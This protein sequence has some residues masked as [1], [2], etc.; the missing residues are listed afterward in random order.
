MYICTEDVFPNLRLQQL[1]AQQR[2]LRTDVP[3]EVVSRI[4]FSNQIFI[5]HVADVVSVLSASVPRG[6][7]SGASGRGHQDRGAEAQMPVHM[8]HTFRSL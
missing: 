1:I 5:E 4:K 3:G 2:R 6:S 7:R 8:C